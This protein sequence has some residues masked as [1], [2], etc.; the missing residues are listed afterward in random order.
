MY[1]Y[2]YIHIDFPA[3]SWLWCSCPKHVKALVSCPVPV[4]TSQIWGQPWWLTRLQSEVTRIGD[5]ALSTKMA[6]NN[7]QQWREFFDSSIPWVAH[8]LVFEITSRRIPGLSLVIPPRNMDTN[9]NG[10][11]VGWFLYTLLD[12]L[13]YRLVAGFRPMATEKVLLWNCWQQVLNGWIHPKS[14]DKTE[15]TEPLMV[16][17]QSAQIHS[18]LP[19][20]LI[21]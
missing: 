16:P 1:S 13:N 8:P 15:H 2:T 4:C 7:P 10:A 14:T 11:A 21:G 20:V 5:M 18:A 17:S 3:S 19:L 9:L 6:V 12:V